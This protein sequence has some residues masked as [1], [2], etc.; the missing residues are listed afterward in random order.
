VAVKVIFAGEN[1]YDKMLNLRKEAAM[2]FGLEHPNIVQ[3]IGLCI[4]LDL[5]ICLVT[6]LVP[7]GN[8][9]ALAFSGKNKTPPFVE[10]IRMMHD[11]V[12]GLA[13]LHRMEPAVIHRDIKPSNLLVDSNSKVA[14][15]GFATT[16]TDNTTMVRQ[17]VL[18][19]PRGHQARDHG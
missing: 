19:G 11:I 3:Y 7:M 8:L 12:Q 14:D 17:P 13:Y 4:A 9:D 15:F 2:L 10:R 5:G 18:V 1:S 16:K 6:E